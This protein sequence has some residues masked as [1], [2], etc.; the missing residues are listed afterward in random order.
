MSS[1]SPTHYALMLPQ[2]LLHWA[3]EGGEAREQDHSL[4]GTQQREVSYYFADLLG[5]PQAQTSNGKQSQA[6]ISSSSENYMDRSVSAYMI[7]TAA[8]QH[9]TTICSMAAA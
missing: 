4:T 5:L 9:H 8:H 6:S 3:L 7:I 1:T 2:G